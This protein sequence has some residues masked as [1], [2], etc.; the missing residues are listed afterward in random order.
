MHVESFRV[1]ER[2]RFSY[3]SPRCIF[4]VNKH[5]DRCVLGLKPT[6]SFMCTW[7]TYLALTPFMCTWKQ[8]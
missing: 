8:K 5:P 3:T 7:K 4:L 6:L 2:K 1:D